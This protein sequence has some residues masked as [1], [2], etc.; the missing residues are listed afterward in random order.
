MHGTN[1]FDLSG[2]VALVTGASK[3]MGRAMAEA[4]VSNGA[5]VI[6][7]SRKQDQLE[8][9]AAEI[10]KGYDKDQVRAISCNMSQ[11]DQIDN[12]VKRAEKTFGPVNV[13]VG[14]AGDNILDGGTGADTITTGSGSD[15][16]VLRLGDGGGALFDADII[17]DFTDGSDIFGLDD[18]L[19]LSELSI[20][21][22]GNDTLIK[23]GS[24]YLAVLTDFD[25]S[26]LSQADFEPVE[27]NQPDV[28]RFY[29]GFKEEDGELKRDIFVE[30]SN[31]FETRSEISLLYWKPG[32]DQTWVTLAR[33]SDGLFRNSD[34][35][36]KYLASGTYEV[37]AL[38]AVDDQGAE[39]YFT[40]NHIENF[41]FTPT[42]E[43][44]NVLSDEIAP[45][46]ENFSISEFYY[47]DIAEKWKIDHS[48]ELSDNLS[49]INPVYIV[50]LSNPTGASIQTMREVDGN[51]FATET[52]EFSKYA[53][54]GDYTLASL[55][56][57][58]V[59]GND[60]SLN[61][62]QMGNLAGI[63][64]VTLDNPYSDDHAP[65]LTNFS[66]SA[67]FN[68]TTGRPS[69]IV[70]F[71]PEDTG[72]SGYSISYVI[73][74][75]PNDVRNDRWVDQ[76]FSDDPGIQYKIDLSTEY[77][78]GTFTVNEF[79]VR[80]GVS[81]VKEYTKS[82]LVAA[83]FNPEINVYFKPEDADSDYIIEASNANDWLI[84][85]NSSDIFDGGKGNDILIAGAGD[86]LLFS[87]SGTDKMIG[88]D[89]SDKFLFS[90]FDGATQTS[91]AD[92]VSDFQ[93]GVDVIGLIGDLSYDQLTIEQGT[94]ENAND[95][96]ISTNDKVLAVLQSTNREE[97]TAADF[98]KVN[99]ANSV[100]GTTNG[101]VLNLSSTTKNV[102]ADTGNDLIVD[103]GGIQ[104]I[105]LGSG[106]DIFVY[107][108]FGSGNVESEMDFIY[109][110]DPTE[111]FIA[112]S[113]QRLPLYNIEQAPYDGATGTAVTGVNDYDGKYFVNLIGTPSE[114]M[115]ENNLIQVMSN[116]VQSTGEHVFLGLQGSKDA[117][118]VFVRRENGEITTFDRPVFADVEQYA[119]SYEQVGDEKRYEV[120]LPGDAGPSYIRPGVFAYEFMADT[121]GES[122]ALTYSGERY[123]E[124]EETNGSVGA[125]ILQFY[126]MSGNKISDEVIYSDQVDQG[127]RANVY[128]IDDENY[129]VLFQTN[130]PIG[131]PRLDDM[132]LYVVGRVV[133]SKTFEMQDT[134]TVAAG[135]NLLK[136]PPSITID[137][138][139]S[140][141]IDWV[142]YDLSQTELG[143]S[144]SVYGGVIDDLVFGTEDDNFLYGEGGNDTINALAGD[145]FLDGGTG[146]DTLEGGA[147]KDYLIGG[148]GV[149]EFLFQAGDGGSS[150]SLA[151]IIS[152][153]ADGVDIIGL[154]GG[155]VFDDLT[156]EQG[157]GDYA[158][159]TIVSNGSEYLMV[160]SDVLATDVDTNDILVY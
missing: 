65:T 48:V 4:L 41:G 110:F 89:G 62:Q 7:S 101:D 103:N 111:D 19:L 11:E 66:L 25:Y 64:S 154:K 150:I 143:R 127:G 99:F 6:I 56:I 49:G 114:E 92:I 43:L 10:N 108:V 155:L 45:T 5:K 135:V 130:N 74:L 31:A 58:D 40:D 119:R 79:T 81:N 83:G 132:V 116:K 125:S 39:L 145:D 144:Y 1:L 151:D 146:N 148:D 105:T 120:W 128:A 20:T 153:F 117:P 159:D 70:D 126:D 152:D 97:I 93:V 121:N 95:T 69:V 32:N 15:T 23:S 156:I 55:R 137:E 76:D 68:D 14:N 44:S 63:T 106:S 84:G 52:R 28:N 147:G 9:V 87:G 91:L 34:A 133:N 142:E 38:A 59:A 96:I 13:L 141:A 53:P 138:N 86:D 3:G 102:F 157:S 115:S 78:P 73:L 122:I 75:D 33:G 29:F 18:G 123:T 71:N 160:L 112:I 57:T 21:Q 27:I 37:R 100:A 12:L 67:D 61:T 77:T 129:L 109:D 107:D 24:E 94:S 22:N 2:K 80:D 30:M 85:T 131:M 139:G 98:E 82:D 104:E 134:F 118:I 149:D 17:T 124:T 35:V 50:E 88:G 16:I 42:F 26:L 47:D 36:N 113:G 136:T 72:G 158:S 60:G 90:A 140:M 46:V 54:S 8:L 51:G